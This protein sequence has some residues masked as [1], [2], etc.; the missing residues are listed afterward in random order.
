LSVFW[1]QVGHNEWSNNSSIVLKTI[2]YGKAATLAAS[3]NDI[4]INLTKMACADNQV[5]KQPLISRS[6]SAVE[7]FHS[8]GR[9]GISISQR[10]AV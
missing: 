10:H 7:S 4:E 8:D 9:I 2:R 5:S 3:T 6:S 1:S